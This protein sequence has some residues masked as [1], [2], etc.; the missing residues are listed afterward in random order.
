MRFIRNVPRKLT[1]RFLVLYM[2]L[3]LLP[4]LLFIGIYSRSLMRQQESEVW[5]QERLR[6]NQS[7]SYLSKSLSSANIIAG[8]FQ[9]EHSLLKM[10]ENGYAS[11]SDELMDYISNVRPVFSQAQATYPDVRD[12]FVYRNARSYLANSDMLFNLPLMDA[13]PYGDRIGLGSFI[14]IS[15]DQARHRESET[16]TSAQ[17]VTLTHLYNRSFSVVLGVLEVQLDLDRVL[18]ALDLP[19]NDGQL[20]LRYDGTVY[21]VVSLSGGLHFDWSG[22]LDDPPT[23][24]DMRIVTAQAPDTDIEMLYIFEGKFDS[25]LSHF[26]SIVSIV[27]TALLV[28]PALIVYL[29][30]YLYAAR[31]TRFGAHLRTR[32]AAELRPFN[33]RS[34]NDELSDVVAAYNDVVA[35]NNDLVKRVRNAEQLKNAATYYA[36]SSQVNPHFMFNTLEN[37]RMQIE[38]ESYDDASQMLF[39]LGRFLRYN[40]SLRRESVLADELTHIEHYLSI[41]QYRVRNLVKYEIERSTGDQDIQLERVRCPFCMLQPIVENCLKHGIRDDGP[42]CIR[43]R[44]ERVGDDLYVDIID[45]GTGVDQRVIGEMNESF[46][47]PE[48]REQAADTHVGLCNVNAR[49]KYFYGD[50][51]G[52]TLMANADEGLTTR[53]RI[54]L[55]P[56]AAP[57][58]AE[59]G[60]YG[61]SGR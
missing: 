33:E 5:Y 17:Y 24:D 2:L 30:V 43:V 52:L 18:T 15:P 9:A 20:Y 51:Y 58:E 56:L 8:L 37:I 53:I 12:V 3:V 40:I 4:T 46:K 36:M 57:D 26:N 38:M 39:V 55:I 49:V 54:S 14:A 29:Y 11:A 7:A 60:R 6:L 35:T 48:I 45:N 32:N 50:S 47:T 19:D 44:M 10:L 61:Y 59:G 31:V 27:P 41:Y 34:H 21:P 1:T 42:I 23:V 22:A 13:F 28:F 16:I 25:S